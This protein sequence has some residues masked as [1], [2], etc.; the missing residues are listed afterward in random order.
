V[1]AQA[2]VATAYPSEN[3]IV[4]T[5][6]K[7]TG[8]FQIAYASGV[9]DKPVAAGTYSLGDMNL[10]H[11]AT[12]VLNTASDALTNGATYTKAAYQTNLNSVVQTMAQSFV[13]KSTV[14]TSKP[15]YQVYETKNSV[16]NSGLISNTSGI[17]AVN[18]VYT[19]KGNYTYY[20]YANTT[21]PTVL[22]SV[23][24]VAQNSRVCYPTKSTISKNTATNATAGVNVASS[25]VTNNEYSTYT[26]KSMGINQTGGASYY[27]KK[28]VVTLNPTFT[29]QA[30]GTATYTISSTDDAYSPNYANTST[31]S[32][33]SGTIS[34]STAD[35]SVTP[36]NTIT[37]CS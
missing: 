21:N 3:N 2:L 15:T 34:T 4:D 19:G 11:Y 31:L 25:S 35:A 33:K 1:A 14:K 37:A 29:S 28:A 7:N 24:D 12:G 16:V 6:Y 36:T 8:N 26:A 13:Q 30:N 22:L 5:Y 17:T 9:T 23:N 20:C 10:N 27:T 32:G 18:Y